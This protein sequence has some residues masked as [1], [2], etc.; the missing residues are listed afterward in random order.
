MSKDV[1]AHVRLSY[2]KIRD[3]STVEEEANGAAT[4][5]AVIPASEILKVGTEGNLRSYIPAHPGKKRSM[6]HKAIG[7]TIR[8]KPDRFSQF[9][10]GFLV[11]ASKIQVDDQKKAVTLWD[12]SVN[13]GAQSQ[14]EIDLYLKECEKLGELPNEFNIRIEISV[15]PDP[16][17]RT[18][19]AIA[20]NTMTRIQD[21][22]QAGKRGYFEDIDSAFRQ[23]HPANKLARSETDIGE[24]FIDT[25]LLLQVL[26]VLMP[27]E[28]MPAGRTSIEARMRAYKNAA[29]CL[30]DF[31]QTYLGRNSDRADA[32]RYKY[33]CDMAGLAW[34]TYRHWRS[35]G[36]WA[37][38]YLRVDARQVRR[39]DG[40]I[41]VA[42]GIVFPALAAL[43]NFVKK[44]PTHS[45]WELSVPSVF[46]EEHLISAAR[47]QL[48]QHQGKPMLMGRS[49]AAYEGLM[50]LTEMA[51]QYAAT[52]AE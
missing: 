14:G 1:G 4:Y 38:Q 8:N 52:P 20:R 24:E 13:N 21:L 48:A 40:Q 15:E 51:N 49:G 18:E 16:A 43:S 22:S 5:M 45:K 29:Q 7:E 42:D 23:M 41:L 2:K 35:H 50:L 28:L 46:R 33:F 19:I 25:R 34:Q 9:N 11:A 26:W 12:A 27:N 47:R 36:E 37:G 17:M 39:K 10:S 32:E 6:V 44:N 3:I 30:S 31:E